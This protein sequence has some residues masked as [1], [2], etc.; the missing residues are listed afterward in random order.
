MQPSAFLHP[1]SFC[2][3]LTPHPVPRATRR[4]SLS[5]IGFGRIDTY[6]KLDKLGEVTSPST[7]SSG[8]MDRERGKKTRD[9]AIIYCRRI[10]PLG[11]G[12]IFRPAEW[13]DGPDQPRDNAGLVCPSYQ[14]R[15]LQALKLVF[16]AAACD[17]IY[18]EP[19][20]K[21]VPVSP[22]ARYGRTLSDL[23]EAPGGRI[24]PSHPPWQTVT[25]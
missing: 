5:E 10:P 16:I 12:L 6:T 2:L 25:G 19:R 18:L 13:S 23:M 11:N 3:L 20:I 4:Q 8:D 24:P 21:I 1:P 7:P 9:K 22:R 14:E 17:G 15:S